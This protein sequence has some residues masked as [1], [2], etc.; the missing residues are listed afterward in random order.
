M[1]LI[2]NNNPTFNSSFTNEAKDL[3][4]KCL[5]MEPKER[6]GWAEIKKHRFFETIDW[7]RLYS[8]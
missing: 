5:N 8:K 1:K 2:L 6:P 7:E 3:I 4:L